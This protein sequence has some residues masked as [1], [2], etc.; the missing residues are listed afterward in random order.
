MMF[1]NVFNYHRPNLTIEMAMQ[2][3]DRTDFMHNQDE[4]A[5]TQFGSVSIIDEGIAK[6]KTNIFCMRVFHC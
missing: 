4:C 6:I 2:K 1:N 5:T 3:S